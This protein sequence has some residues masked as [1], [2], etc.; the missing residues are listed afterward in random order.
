MNFRNNRKAQNIT[1]P[2]TLILIL[3]VIVL[4]STLM[5]NFGADY[6]TDPNNKLNNESLIYIFEKSGFS[7]N[8]NITSGDTQDLFFTSDTD[9]EGNL[10]DFALEFQFYREQSSG[11][12]TL[13]QDVWNVPAFF[14]NGFG[15]DSSLWVTAIQIWNTIIWSLVL[16]SIYRF[17]RGLI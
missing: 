12:R 1:K 17:L 9:N 2:Y 15:L 5:F 6:A 8:D 14:V 13:I 7:I 10:K 16:F 11:I 4:V 3:V